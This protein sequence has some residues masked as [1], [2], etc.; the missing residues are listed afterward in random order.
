MCS[1]Q[2]SSLCLCHHWA[3]IILFSDEASRQTKAISNRSYSCTHSW[4]CYSNPGWSQKGLSSTALLLNTWSFYISVW[5]GYCAIY[6]DCPSKGECR[7][8]H[9]I[10]ESCQHVKLS[11]KSV[12][13]RTLFGKCKWF[14]TVNETKI[15]RIA[16]IFDGLKTNFAWQYNSLWKRQKSLQYIN[17][18][19]FTA[20]MYHTKFCIIF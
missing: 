2:F 19:S 5:S 15:R 12:N 14:T 6:V 8:F 20:E 9:I 1:W 10:F 16:K 11:T 18:N 4:T 7:G 17:F 13:K 3:S